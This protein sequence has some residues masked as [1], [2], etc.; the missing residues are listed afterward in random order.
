MEVSK[1]IKELIEPLKFNYYQEGIVKYYRKKGTL[2]EIDMASTVINCKCQ[3]FNSLF[4]G[5]ATYSVDLDIAVDISSL[6]I[7]IAIIPGSP[8]LFW[9]YGKP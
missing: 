1:T 6:M 7:A 5:K 3:F 4:F 8:L 2:T 9:S